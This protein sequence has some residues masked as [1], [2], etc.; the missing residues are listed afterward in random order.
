MTNRQI[1]RLLGRV[2]ESIPAQMTEAGFN[3]DTCILHSR[4]AVDVLR[5]LGV[6]AR[7]LACRMMAGN[8]SWR[9]LSL[10]L[11]RYPVPDEWEP[12]TWCLGIG[13][14][15]DPRL[16]RPRYDGHVIVVVNERWAVDLTL[17]QASR[18]AKGMELRP[19]FWQVEREFLRGDQPEVFFT[20]GG[21][22]VTYFPLPEERG[23][24]TVP[25]WTEPKVRLARLT[26]TPQIVAALSATIQR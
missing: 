13:Y 23:F 11:G 15:P 17:D 21:S 25:D 16:E 12:E 14:G 4:V 24:L 20:E 3:R 2:V 7:P 26:P 10:K 19:H 9:A 5:E 8:D 1:E 18:P 22:V 6:R